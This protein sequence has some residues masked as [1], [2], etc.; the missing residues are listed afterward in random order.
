[1]DQRQDKLFGSVIKTAIIWALLQVV[2][3]WRG[4]WA[5]IG[6]GYDIWTWVT[7][8]LYVLALLA[9]DIFLYRFNHVGAAKGWA[10]Y[11]LFS[12]VVLLLAWFVHGTDVLDA[13]LQ[14]L[15][16][17]TTPYYTVYPLWDQL[18]DSKGFGPFML[19]LCAA[20]LVYLLLQASRAKKQETVE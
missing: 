19:A 16:I 18:F 17:F 5:L 13:T 9:L 12:A 6:Y 10:K 8:A 14:V 1:M 4:F 15:L 11:W 2:G 7:I 20:H 3:G